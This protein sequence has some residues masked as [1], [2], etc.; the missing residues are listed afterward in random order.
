MASGGFSAVPYG[1]VS[2]GR[3]AAGAARITVGRDEFVHRSGD[4]F[5]IADATHGFTS[6]WSNAD[7]SVVRLPVSTLHRVAEGVER[8]SDPKHRQRPPLRFF[9]RRPETARAARRWVQVVL[10]V[11]RHLREVDVADD[12]VTGATGDL[13]AASLL[14]TFPNSLIRES[15]SVSPRGD[16]PVT[17]RLAVDYL[18]RNADLPVTLSDVA[19]HSSVTPR[20]LQLAFRAHLATSPMAYL[21]QRRLDLVHDELRW[22]TPGEGASVTDI[23]ARWTFTESSRLVAHYRRRYGENPSATL[24]R[25]P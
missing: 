23:A 11:E 1:T 16:L 5:L 10:F 19:A 24:R 25:R 13:L 15:G 2:V 17:V 9:S 6:L 21:R 7:C 22:A 20:A 14:T 12:L 18:E 8:G 3:L 4:V